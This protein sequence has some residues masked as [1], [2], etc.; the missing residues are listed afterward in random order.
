MGVDSFSY[1][2]VLVVHIVAVVVAFGIPLSRTQDRQARR[3]ADI[4]LYSVPVWG[5][6]LV[7]LSDKEIKFSEAWVSVSFLLWIVI[8]GV[9]HALVAPTRD[10]LEE[11]TDTDRPALIQRLRIGTGF[12][13]VVWV[14]VVGLMVWKPGH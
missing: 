2:L 13:N 11:A 14:V 8:V 4:A 12:N 3:M 5:M 6:A 7:G 10:R 9:T 1:K